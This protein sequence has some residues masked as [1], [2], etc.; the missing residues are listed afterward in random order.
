M[1]RDILNKAMDLCVKEIAQRRENAGYSGSMGDDGAGA[2]QDEL[3]AFKAGLYGELPEFLKEHY[4][5][6]QRNLDPEYAEYKRLQKKF[7]D[8]Q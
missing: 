1:N 6:V 2:L 5:E 4:Q 7:E 3:T 8:A